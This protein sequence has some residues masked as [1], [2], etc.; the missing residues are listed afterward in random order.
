MPIKFL[1]QS[2]TK[3]GGGKD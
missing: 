2:L 1:K 3:G